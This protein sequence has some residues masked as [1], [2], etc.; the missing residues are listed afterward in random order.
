MN[1]TSASGSTSLALFFYLPSAMFLLIFPSAQVSNMCS[2][3]VSPLI[4]HR[5]YYIH[6]SNI[7][8]FGVGL[9]NLAPN[10]AE[11]KLFEQFGKDIKANAASAGCW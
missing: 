11:A 9:L 7:C 5:D 1:P 2:A 6:G 3:P 4:T 10:S 8:G